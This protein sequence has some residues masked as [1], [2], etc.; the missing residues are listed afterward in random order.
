MCEPYSLLFQ[1][2]LSNLELAILSWF[3]IYCFLS[4]LFSLAVD[5]QGPLAKRLKCTTI[6]TSKNQLGR[7]K[8]SLVIILV[9]ENKNTILETCFELEDETQGSGDY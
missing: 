9:F 8:L 3:G 7:L 6:Q 1:N 2:V 4:F 5:W